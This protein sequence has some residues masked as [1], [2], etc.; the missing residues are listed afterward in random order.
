MI[1]A[2]NIIITM[3]VAAAAGMVFKTSHEVSTLESRLNTLNQEIAREQ[4][5]IRVLRAEWAYLNRPERLRVLAEDY[6]A[7]RTSTGDQ[8][9]ASVADIPEPLQ[10][11]E[12]F[13]SFPVPAPKPDAPSD[14]APPIARTAPGDEQGDEPVDQPGN[15]PIGV[16]LARSDNGGAQ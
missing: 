14:E 10:G 3:A 1:R 13:D 8:M 6:S 2:S 7:L 15:D 5:A 12:V 9:I 11:P 16:L 4:E